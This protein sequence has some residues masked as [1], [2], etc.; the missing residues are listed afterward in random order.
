MSKL[1]TTF[2][3]VLFSCA[4][5][6]QTII[7]PKLICVTTLF[8]GNIELEWE[9]PPSQSCGSFLGYNIYATSNL[10]LPFTLLATVTNQ[11]QTTF[12]HINANGNVQTWYYYLTTDLQC[13]TFQVG[14]SEVLDNLDPETPP[15][16]SV[17]INNNGNIV[18]N[19]EASLSPE[20]DAYVIY[21]ETANGFIAIDTVFGG[22]TTFEHIGVN[23]DV[24]QTYTIAAMDL[25]GNIGLLYDNPHQTILLNA[26]VNRCEQKIDLTWDEY[27]SW[28]N[29]VEEYRVYA[30]VSG[31]TANL[32]KTVEG[33]VTS[34]SI[35]EF[36]DEEEVCVV[37][38]AVELGTGYISTT[39][40]ICMAFD[41]VE[42]MDYV[43]LSNI[44][45]NDNNDLEVF[46]NW[47][48]DAD[49]ESYL[50]S[51]DSNNFILSSQNTLQQSAY[52]LDTTII[53]DAGSFNVQITGVD[54]CQSTIT[55]VS[56]Y[57]I[58]LQGIPNENYEN[59]LN[60][61]P[62]VL[63]YATIYSYQI[64]RIVQNVPELIGTVPA[65][66]FSFVDMINGYDENQADVN[67]YVVA[68][69]FIE[70]PDGTSKTIFSRSN[71]I[72]IEQ[73]SRI[74]MPNAFA[75][76]GYNYEFKPV[77]VFSEN[78]SFQMFIY[79]R[80]GRLIFETTDVSK[81]WNGRKSNGQVYRQGIY[82]YV[83]KIEQQGGEVIEKKGT[84]FLLR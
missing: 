37:V 69:A 28:D 21:Q 43:Y 15:I 27:T 25:C 12:T 76:E 57:T 50:I 64:Y 60:W 14:Q 9:L 17:S 8:D 47:D 61:T 36:T 53:S 46:W 38:Q 18:L 67:Y 35:E 2:I 24:N 30:R 68:Q 44:S 29:P 63:E 22:L 80:W 51:V 20:T 59:I 71:T 73:D 56:G 74:F 84:V 77:L 58:F 34:T 83:V 54:S 52:Y 39:Q 49:L 31:G 4:A 23:A 5:F 75:P 32:I 78:S 48:T 40:E 16:T 70:L 45:I 19:W 81:G 79:D 13:P 82:T 66:E 72:L 1:I 42:P 26:T 7:P 3:L 10:S 55:S 62:L 65:S 11:T 41:V 6:S 33:T